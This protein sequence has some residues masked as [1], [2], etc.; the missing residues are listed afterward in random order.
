MSSIKTE[1]RDRILIRYL[2]RCK[3]TNALAFFQWRFLVLDDAE[4]RQKNKAIF[5]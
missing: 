3:V 1:D 5:Y 4:G 2:A